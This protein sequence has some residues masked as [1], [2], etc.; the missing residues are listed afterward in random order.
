MKM[1]MDSM[2][3]AESSEIVAEDGSPVDSEALQDLDRQ[4]AQDHQE[5]GFRDVK[6]LEKMLED[7][8]GKDGEKIEVAQ[9]NYSSEKPENL[10]DLDRVF[11]GIKNSALKETPEEKNRKIEDV[12]A[13]IARLK[14]KARIPTPIPKKQKK[15]VVYKPTVVIKEKTEK[16]NLWKKFKGFFSKRNGEK[17]NNQRRE[18]FEA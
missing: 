10:V 17:N 16:G 3:E 6:D 4:L 2:P 15:A 5:D 12:Q 7:I 1:K 18:D 11:S 9:S 14:R 8:T 13:Q